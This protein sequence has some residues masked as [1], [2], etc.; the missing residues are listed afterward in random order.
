MTW[1]S[2][3][4]SGDIMNELYFF[5]FLLFSKLRR[6]FKFSHWPFSTISTQQRAI[7]RGPQL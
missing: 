3:H 6:V 2:I 4:F 1:L 5:V 7:H